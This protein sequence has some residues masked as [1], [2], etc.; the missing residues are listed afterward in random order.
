MTI[1]ENVSAV[2][3]ATFAIEIIYNGVDK[4]LPHVE[5]NEQVGAV[6][7]R[8]LHLFDVRDRPHAYALFTMSGQELSNDQTVHYAG[9]GPG[10][11]LVL[12]EKTVVGG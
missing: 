1:Q 2:G 8:A 6:L 10:T 12:R 7:K 11:E 9:I 5:R 4:P 3:L